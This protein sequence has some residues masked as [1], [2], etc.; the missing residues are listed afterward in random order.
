MI[1]NNSCYLHNSPNCENCERGGIEDIMKTKNDSLD[2]MVRDFTSIVPRNKSEVKKR[3][4]SY[5]EKA[6]NKI[7]DYFPLY[8][9]R[10][11]I[12]VLAKLEGAEDAKTA[13]HLVK[14]MIL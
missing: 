6:I 11:L 12:E 5:K 2:S 14:E 3:I 7:I 9:E 1:Y 4:F 10:I 8:R 13:R